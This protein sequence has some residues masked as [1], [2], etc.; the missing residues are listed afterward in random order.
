MMDACLDRYKSTPAEVTNTNN[1]LPLVKK[2]TEINT[3]KRK[4][5]NYTCVYGLF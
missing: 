1:K 4:Q 5:A 3:N 2:G